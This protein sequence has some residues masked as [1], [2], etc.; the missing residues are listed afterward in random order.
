MGKVFD[1]FLWPYTTLKI[2]LFAGYWKVLEKIIFPW[3][4]INAVYFKF[5]FWINSCITFGKYSWIVNVS[6]LCDFSLK[7]YYINGHQI[8]IPFRELTNVSKKSFST[9]RTKIKFFNST[10]TT[11]WQLLGTNCRYCFI[12]CDVLSAD[13][14]YVIISFYLD[15]IYLTLQKYTKV[16]AK[17]I[18]SPRSFPRRCICSNQRVGWGEPRV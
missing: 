12:L 5:I 6:Q 14:Y 13:T 7:D 10:I 11:Y 8:A 1:L 4:I 16:F 15:V 17:Q 2:R 18:L 3:P 9:V